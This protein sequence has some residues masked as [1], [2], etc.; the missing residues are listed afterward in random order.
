[1]PPQ[2]AKLAMIFQKWSFQ[3]EKRP[4]QPVQRS[5]SVRDSQTYYLSTSLSSKSCT[6]KKNTE[7]FR[8]FRNTKDIHFATMMK[9]LIN[10]S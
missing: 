6:F 3:Q 1:V 8:K 10:Y 9:L 7:K 5:F 4:W 2:A